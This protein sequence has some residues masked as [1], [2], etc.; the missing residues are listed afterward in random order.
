MCSRYTAQSSCGT[1][2][3]DQGLSLK[4]LPIC[5]SCAPVEMPCLVSVE[6]MHLALQGC[7]VLVVLGDT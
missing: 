5:G 7:D 4:L 6:R 3:L 2:Q 1:Q